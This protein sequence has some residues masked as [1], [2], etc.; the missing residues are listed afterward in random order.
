M[1]TNVTP[2]PPPPPPF[3]LLR[4][5]LNAFSRFPSPSLKTKNFFLLFPLLPSFLPFF[6][7]L[8]QYQGKTFERPHRFK[9]QTLNLFHLFSL[10][11]L[12]SF[13]FQLL[14]ALL[15]R[16]NFFL[17]IF[18]F[19]FVFFRT[20]QCQFFLIKKLHFSFLTLYSSAYHLFL[21]L[22]ASLLLLSFSSFGLFY[23]IFSFSSFQ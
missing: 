11:S 9:S 7:L 14:F 8:R 16:T 10:L 15:G 23:S 2:V 4:R 5:P 22:S 17:P 12:W 3:R 20:F 18:L 6:L 1:S 21:L 13:R 19:N